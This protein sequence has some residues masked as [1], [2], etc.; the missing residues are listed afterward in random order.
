MRGLHRAAHIHEVLGRS[1][2][3]R[4][5]LAEQRRLQVAVDLA[6]PHAPFLEGYQA[7]LAQVVGFFVV[8]ME[9]QRLAPM[10][11]NP[12]AT[13]YLWEGAAAQLQSVLEAQLCGPHT[14]PP[15]QSAGSGG[16]A[17]PAP[18][19]APPHRTSTASGFIPGLGP[20]RDPA[21]LA[22]ALVLVKDF[23]L[24]VCDALEELGCGTGPLQGVLVSAGLRYHELLASSC[25]KSV[26]AVLS[27]DPLV[28]G[29]EVRTE[30]QARELFT[31]LGL[32]DRLDTP[33]HPTGTGGGAP[34][35][36]AG[37]SGGSGPQRAASTRTLPHR[38]PFTPLVPEVLRVVRA[39][40]ADS[41]PYLSGLLRPWEV[42]AAALHQRDRLIAR[43]VVEA[44]V[45]RMNG[46]VAESRAPALMWL[47]AD[48]W[49]LAAAAPELDLFTCAQAAPRA[50]QAELEAVGRQVQ[51]QL[52]SSASAAEGAQEGEAQAAQIRR[53]GF[54]HAE[55][56]MGNVQ[57]G[58]SVL[59]V[60]AAAFRALQVAAERALL[61][62]V[63]ARVEGIV[64]EGLK[65]MVWTPSGP[66]PLGPSPYVEALLTF[67][68]DTVASAG[69]VLPHPSYVFMC[70]T[71]LKSTALMLLRLF[72]PDGIKGYNLF[73][74]EKLA[75]D[76]AAVQAF[77]ASVTA[78][79]GFAAGMATGTGGSLIDEF[80][81]PAQLCRLLLSDTLED[82][83]VPELRR[84]RYPNLE[85]PTIVQ[86]LD[87]YR[88]ILKVGKEKTR[89][90]TKKAVDQITKQLRGQ[91]VTG[92]AATVLQDF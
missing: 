82:V 62:L 33:G 61:R 7:Y 14:A 59:G 12:A 87:K 26:S 28:A 53:R 76:V 67:M 35:T 5:Y 6:P 68:Q 71:A 20:S 63:S 38:C 44:L 21:A 80:V 51:A 49:A 19:P 79:T 65:A 45:G 84:Q 74:I 77:A 4:D 88:E 34:P 58:G 42:A 27:S 92:S 81:E 9:V 50:E 55:G 13:A 41:V 64:G 39:F 15:P 47:V 1:G 10:L 48:A 86:A 72:S 56:L 30:V 75:A 54:R 29:L 2:R 52:S 17:R 36:S 43:V 24:L 69:G 46:L 8:E 60:A 91:M 57:P 66:L 25:T 37:S 11:A 73:A 16:G 3:L 31:M 40:V 32:P 83:L 23:V 22:P 89:F 78:G 18:P 70:R 85:P 90:P